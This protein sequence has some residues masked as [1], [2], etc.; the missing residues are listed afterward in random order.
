[1]LLARGRFDAAVV[2]SDTAGNLFALLQS[3]FCLRRVPTV[4]VDCL[5]YLPDSP[6]ARWLKALQ[7]RLEARAVSRFVVWAEHEVQSYSQAFGIPE[8]KFRFVPFHITLTG[9]EYEVATGEYIFSGGNGD[10]DYATLVNAVRGL[11]TRTIIATT[12]H[13]AFKGVSIPPNVSVVKC[14]H[15]RFR[16]LMAEAWIVVVP[17][18]AGHLHSGGQQTY[19]NAMAMGKPVVICDSRGAEG[20]VK[21]GVDGVVVG[22]GDTDGLRRAIQLLLDRPD[23][24]ADL[25]RQAQ[26]RIQRGGYGTEDCMR[27][28]AYLALTEARRSG[29]PT[30]CASWR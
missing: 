5:W 20:Y 2:A 8:R 12:N 30:E 3:L 18:E 21:D 27:A 28:V 19:L 7:L 29:A 6:I 15:A 14:D 4:M 25:G 11:R 16:R 13:A 1:M 10:R 22:S 23:L 9:Y 17:M 26:Q 24:A